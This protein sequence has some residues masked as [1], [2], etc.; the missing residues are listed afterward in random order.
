[1]FTDRAITRMYTWL[2]AGLKVAA[3][4]CI[5]ARLM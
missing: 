2:Y 1:M 5:V 3:A 4:A